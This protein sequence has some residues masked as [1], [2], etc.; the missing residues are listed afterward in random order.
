MGQASSAREDV[1]RGQFP[2]L[3][4]AMRNKEFAQ[5]SV[6]RTVASVRATL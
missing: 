1:D 2:A 3:S 5:Q 4:Y 6:L